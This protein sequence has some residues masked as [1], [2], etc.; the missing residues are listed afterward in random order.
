MLKKKE[1]VEEVKTQH[2]VFNYI[3]PNI[4]LLWN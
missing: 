1:E 4:C 2:F 3:I